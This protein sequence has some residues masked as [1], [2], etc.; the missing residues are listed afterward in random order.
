MIIFSFNLTLTI[1]KKTELD[2]SGQEFQIHKMVTA[3][4]REF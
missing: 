3:K 2:E 1:A 4:M